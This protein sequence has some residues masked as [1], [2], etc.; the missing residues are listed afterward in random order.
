MSIEKTAYTVLGYDLSSYRNQLLTE[1]F[2][3]SDTFEGITN[4]EVRL[5]TGGESDENFLCFGLP[6]YSSEECSE[7]PPKTICL[8]AIEIVRRKVDE[9]WGKW[10]EALARIDKS[11]LPFELICF[12]EYR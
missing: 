6:V 1:E 7:S 2:R 9:E 12:E 5:F 10:S 8:S 11:K 4:G 3:W